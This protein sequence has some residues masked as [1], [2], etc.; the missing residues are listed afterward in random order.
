MGKLIL[1]LRHMFKLNGE[2]TVNI[3]HSENLK[4]IA[5]TTESIKRLNE[6]LVRRSVAYKI[7]NASGVRR[8]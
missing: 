5:K 8:I 3:L 2:K 1:I 4:E 7:Y 6:E